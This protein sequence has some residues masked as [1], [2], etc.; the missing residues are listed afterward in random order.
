MGFLLRGVSGGTLRVVDG[1]VTFWVLLWMVVALLTGWAVWQLTALTDT[2]VESGMALDSAGQG[3]A[4]LGDI[5]FIGEV[6]R[7]LGMQVRE[8]AE[9]IRTSGADAE[10]TVKRIAILLGLAVLLM[11]TLPLLLAYLPP[12]L[13]RARELRTLRKALSAGDGG[14]V[15]GYLAQQALQSLPYDRLR[16]VSSDPWKDLATGQVRA[17]ADTQ[18]DHLGVR[19]PRSRGASRH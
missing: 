6:P 5:P 9:D 16:R 13:A 3:I 8:T 19:R 17:L 18:L 2:V 14:D 10:G 11:P 4:S 15:D 12:R 1:L 7:Q